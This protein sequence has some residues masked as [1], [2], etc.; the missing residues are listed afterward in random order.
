MRFFLL[1]IY[2]QIFLNT[3]I[4]WHVYPVLPRKR[5]L[6]V[7]FIVF[8]VLELLLFF[9]GYFCYKDL[10]DHILYPIMMVCNTWYIASIYISFGLLW[11][12]LVK[13]LIRKVRLKTI[14]IDKSQWKK[15]Q[16]GYFCFLIVFVTGLMIKAYHNAIYP[17]I[18]HVNIHIPKEVEGRD[19]LTIVLM[20]DLHIGETIGKRNVQRFVELCNAEQPDMVV[21]AGDM[22]DYESRDA[23]K[24]SIEEDLQRLNASLGVY[25]VL[26]N[27][28]YRAN[29][30]AKFRWFE[31]TGGI[32][33]V[34]SVV[35]PDSSFYLIGRD[36]VI[37]TERASL[38]TLMQDVDRSKPVIVVEHQPNFAEDI[39]KNQCDLGLF[40][41]THNGQ[42]WPFSLLLKLVF[43][44]SNGYYSR[45]NAHIYISSGIGFAGPPYR[46]GTRS[47]LVVIK[48]T[49]NN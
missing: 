26:G 34:D 37:N 45:E 43:K 17:E 15:V 3:Y 21:I 1:S 24:N 5:T 13:V 46:V 32:L 4:I 9:T 31:K 6:R 19:S 18:R 47:E 38:E 8:F 22:L 11:L 12:D 42:Y 28:E 25:M 10:P 44:F 27:H 23:E 16:I 14:E 2:G 49:M 35:M 29:R 36:D 40:G 39:I 20:S 48:L 33:L 30:F 41:H 7:P